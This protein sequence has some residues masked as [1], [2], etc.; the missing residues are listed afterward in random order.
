LLL[1]IEAN[2]TGM[3]GTA[4]IYKAQAKLT[5]PFLPGMELPISVSVANRTEFLQ[6]KEVKGKFGFTFDISKVLKAFR[7]NFQPTP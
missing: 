5:I 7:D 6:E 1:S 3:T 4:P 2:A